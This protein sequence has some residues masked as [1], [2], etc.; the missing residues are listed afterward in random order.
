MFRRLCRR[1]DGFTLV[2]LL[3]V[4][5]IIGVL[6]G[7]AIPVYSNQRAKGIDAQVTSQINNVVKATETLLADATGPISGS[8]ATSTITIDDA[9]TAV[10]TT[11]G[12]SW[13][14]SG[15]GGI[16]CIASWADAGK[17]TEDTPQYY[18]STVGRVL[19]DGTDC[20]TPIDVGDPGDDE[21]PGGGEP[22][23]TPEPE[24]PYADTFTR[25]SRSIGG[26]GVFHNF[27]IEET[28]ISG[29]KR[30]IIFADWLKPEPGT[31]EGGSS[32]NARLRC[33]NTTTLEITNGSSNTPLRDTM[34][35]TTLGS[36][37]TGYRAITECPD[38]TEPY[39]FAWSPETR[40][41]PWWVSTE[42]LEINGWPT[43]AAD[44][45]ADKLEALAAE[46]GL[47]TRTRR[48]VSDKGVMDDIA[49]TITPTGKWTFEVKATMNWTRT[50]ASGP[51]STSNYGLRCISPNGTLE[52]RHQ[53]TIVNSSGSSNISTSG[54]YRVAAV[55]CSQGYIPYD[56]VSD[57]ADTSPVQADPWWV[58][59]RYIDL[60]GT[61]PSVPDPYLDLLP[62]LEDAQ[63][64]SVT[65]W[66]VDGV[67]TL[68]ELVFTVTENGPYKYRVD[69]T[70]KWSGP[71]VGST[72]GKFWLRCIS[73]AGVIT[74]VTNSAIANSSGS[75][76]L[77]AAGNYRL[78]NRTC[79]EGSVPYDYVATTSGDLS[80][81]VAD[82]L[83]VSNRWLE[84]N[85]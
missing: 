43:P 80:P 83:W 68:T 5:V 19:P 75:S 35:S 55:K 78:S 14:V 48:S 41:D 31:I 62:S 85:G 28:P 17:Y 53:G 6:A 54:A 32:A 81:V 4:V 49:F 61:P 47:V 44:P 50:E 34:L 10:A 20:D 72:S 84:L 13:T 71:S 3:V 9:T 33:I 25:P 23:P 39:D 2:E 57:R 36:S 69:A 40:N 15:E 65:S 42:Y 51:G 8:S 63:G 24:A 30:V 7:I 79:A 45:Y 18:D 56:Y 26:V 70:F 77:G 29:G 58:S 74:Q 38:G 22:T 82:P 21:T 76:T 66:N 46:P 12:I 59:E 16:Y 64:E 60:N 27:T 67:G 37:K 1:D 73:P 11:D 52:V